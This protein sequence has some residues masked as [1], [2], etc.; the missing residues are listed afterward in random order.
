MFQKVLLDLVRPTCP[1]LQRLSALLGRVEDLGFVLCW[2]T[3]EA[4][5]EPSVQATSGEAA[6]GEISSG[7]ALARVTS[8]E[9][10]RLKLRLAPRVVKGGVVRLV[11]LDHAGWYGAG[12]SWCTMLYCGD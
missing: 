10:P 7:N 11:L 2:A 4:S 9:L 5:P 1:S 6:S 3:P 8:I 12:V